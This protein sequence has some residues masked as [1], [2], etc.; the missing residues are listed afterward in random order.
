MYLCSGCVLDERV[1]VAPGGSKNAT[2]LPKGKFV[3]TSQGALQVSFEKVETVG[4]WIVTSKTE[5]ADRYVE[6]DKHTTYG[7][8]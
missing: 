8:C 3:T 5:I 6:L 4:N 7:I 1:C 2:W